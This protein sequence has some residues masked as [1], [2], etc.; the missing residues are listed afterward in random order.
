MIGSHAEQSRGIGDESQEIDNVATHKHEV[1]HT[2]GWYLRKYV[3]D[4]RAKSARPI[5]LSLTTRDV[6]KEGRVEVG[7]NQY[8]ESA[9]RVALA[10]DHTDFVDASAIIAAQYEKLGP[11]K[12]F[13]LFHAKEP[14]HL[15]TAGAFLD[16]QLI[17]AGLKGLPDSPVT[18]FLSYLGQQVTPATGT[19]PPE[20]S[21]PVSASSPH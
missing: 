1:V 2:F 18:P 15:N 10:E 6:W 16:A 12:T 11:D 17:V 3:E 21:Q 13:G 20:W 4:T 5:V 8:R 9:Y 7:V 14:V 19:A